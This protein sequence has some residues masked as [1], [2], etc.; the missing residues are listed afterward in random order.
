MAEELD[1][2]TYPIGKAQNLEFT[3]DVLYQSILMIESAPVRL[4]Q[5]IATLNEEELELTYREGSWTIRQIV[6][7]LADSH[8]NMW[9][10]FKHSLTT[11]NPT[12][13]PY[14]QNVWADSADYK[15]APLE[16]SL[17]IFEGIQAR[18]SN[19]LKHMSESDFKRTYT[20]PEYKKVFTLAEATQLYAWHGLHHAAQIEGIFK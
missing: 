1:P 4:R 12:I 2:K 7:H 18:F 17:L 10:R 20:H 11:D 19:L 9:I 14:N 3:K 8:M 5:R 15:S 6:H 16:S 13:L